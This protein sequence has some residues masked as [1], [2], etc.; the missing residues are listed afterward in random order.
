MGYLPTWNVFSRHVS[1]FRVQLSL[2]GGK[3]MQETIWTTNIDSE[4]HQFLVETH[5]PTLM[6]ARVYLNLLEGI[7]PSTVYLSL[8]L[9]LSIYIYIH[10]Y[11][12]RV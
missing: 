5:L 10:I 9:S 3:Q 7:Y 4:N 1:C 8:S 11:V 2:A 6:N 12:Q